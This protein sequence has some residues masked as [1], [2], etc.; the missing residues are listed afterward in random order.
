MT[1]TP[2]SPLPTGR[3]AEVGREKE[4]GINLKMEVKPMNPFSEESWEQFREDL[5]IKRISSG[6][7]L[8]ERKT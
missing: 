6:S 3:Q 4:R 7:L 5:G 2:S 8:H 1:P